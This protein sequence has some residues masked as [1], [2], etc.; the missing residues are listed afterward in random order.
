MVDDYI[1]QRSKDIHR[2]SLTHKDADIF[3]KWSS[4]IGMFL[5]FLI[6][7]LFIKIFILQLL[8]MVALPCT[9]YLVLKYI[10]IYRVTKSHTDF[11]IERFLD[12]LYEYVFAYEKNKI[13]ELKNKS[14]H[15]LSVKGNAVDLGLSV[16]WSDR[17][18]GA[19]TECNGCPEY[20]YDYYENIIG[21]HFDWGETGP[22]QKVC[23]CNVTT[24]EL[25]RNNIIDDQKRLSD[26]YDAAKVNWGTPWRMPTY[27]E[28]Q[29]LIDLCEWEYCKQ[30]GYDGY[31]VTGPNGSSI[32][33][34]LGGEI[35]KGEN[36]CQNTGFYWIGQLNFGK[37]GSF[38]KNYRQ[39]CSNVL[40]LN[41][42]SESKNPVYIA[43]HLRN[44]AC[45]IRPVADKDSIYPVSDLV[46]V[47]DF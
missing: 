42:D 10:C 4:Y 43:Y 46:D 29:E 41:K 26:E 45:L 6:T 1:K 5:L 32:F 39:V 28:V 9:Y 40:L 12:D 36:T 21:C 8:L 16:Y 24:L 30:F 37:D 33:L 35:D 18:I 14:L 3:F 47:F 15:H 23:M 34:P 27:D 13:V 19:Y 31:K 11:R 17:N 38:F 22:N 44:C 25:K 2:F 20:G 7:Y